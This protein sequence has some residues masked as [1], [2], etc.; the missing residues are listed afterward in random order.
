MFRPMSGRGQKGSNGNAAIAKT[1]LP[2]RLK[3]VLR[4]IVVS[5]YDKVPSNAPILN[6]AVKEIKGWPYFPVLD[7]G[8]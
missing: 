3:N 5:V 8:Y 4:F 7:L 2:I 6:D 1:P